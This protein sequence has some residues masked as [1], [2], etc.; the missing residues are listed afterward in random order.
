MALGTGRTLQLRTHPLA[1]CPTGATRKRDHDPPFSELA[2]ASAAMI[3]AGHGTNANIAGRSSFDSSPG[4]LAREERECTWP[5]TDG[6]L[7]DQTRTEGESSARASTARVE[8]E[9]S[10]DS[11]DEGERG[12]NQPLPASYTMHERPARRSPQQ[13]KPRASR[14]CGTRCAA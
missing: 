12:P 10:E 2:G 9:D 6:Q 5:Q 4:H 3:P 7:G 13:R 1:L 14:P 8:D 11:E